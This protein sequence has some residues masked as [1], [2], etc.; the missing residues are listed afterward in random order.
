ML[1]PLSSRGKRL[2]RAPALMDDEQIGIVTSWLAKT[3]FA[4]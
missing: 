3:H 1:A 2:R 4:R